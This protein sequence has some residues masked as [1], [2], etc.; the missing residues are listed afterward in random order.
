MS[1]I[2]HIKCIFNCFPRFTSICCHKEDQSSYNFR[3]CFFWI[4]LFSRSFFQFL[5]K[6]TVLEY[7]H[8]NFFQLFASGVVNAA[9]QVS[10]EIGDSERTTKYRNSDI[11]ATDI[12]IVDPAT[13]PVAAPRKRRQ[14]S[15]LSGSGSFR[16][17]VPA[18][19][20]KESDLGTRESAE[21]VQES[22]SADVERRNVEISPIIG[23]TSNEQLSQIVTPMR[24]INL[25]YLYS[26][27]SSGFTGNF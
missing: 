5:F 21:Y 24:R 22:P 13:N 2:P 26:N 11:P 7:F 10:D 18:V 16:E 15:L 23:K 6:N 8:P 27:N 9:F 17:A 19:E 12:E 1:P 4:D 25:F 3:F 14:G 20:D